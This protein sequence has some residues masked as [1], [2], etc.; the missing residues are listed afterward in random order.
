MSDWHTCD[1]CE[2]E[3]KV[4]TALNSVPQ[5]CPFCGTETDMTEED[6]WNDDDEQLDD[7]IEEE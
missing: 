3:Y 7:E 4:V 1:V 2:A 6:D 5:Y